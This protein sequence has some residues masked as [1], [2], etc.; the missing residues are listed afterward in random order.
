MSFDLSH[1]EY[2]AYAMPPL[3]TSAA[4]LCL[5]LAVVL[6]ERGSP[7][8]R[9]LFLMLGTT[10]FWLFAF[11]W[12]YSASDESTAM[13]WAE[14]AYLDVP[15]ICVAIYHVTVVV[16]GL[17]QQRRRLVS[18]SWALSAIFASSTLWSD[19]L[20]AGVHRY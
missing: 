2:N 16:L 18:L 19:A 20:V 8:S 10:S 15:F 14:L 3:F 6:R 9:I 5:G 13:W 12:M 4:L 11:S 7:V 17:Y 1:Y